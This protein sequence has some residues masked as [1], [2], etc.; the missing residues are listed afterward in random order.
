MEWILWAA[1][2]LLTAVVLALAVKIHLLRRSAREIAAGLSMRL[3]TDTNT[4][5]GISS[6]DRAMRALAESINTDLRALRRE[7]RRLQQGDR[8]LRE[9]VTNISHDLR[10]PLTSIAGTADV[11]LE[12]GPS[13]DD[14][15]RGRLLAGIRDDA[16]WLRDT[17][18][19]LLTVTR[20]EEGGVRPLAD[21]ELVDDLVEEALRHAAADP[22]HPV[23]FEPP[24]GPL[25]VRAD[26]SLV[27]QALVNLVNNAVAHT[28]AGCAVTVFAARSG[29]SVEL[30][31]ADDGPGI[32]DSEKDRIFEAFHSGSGTLPDGTRSAGLGLSVCRAVARAHGGGIRVRDR[33]PHGSV[34]VLSL[35][36]EEVPDV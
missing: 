27:V 35:P 34:F 24:E 33:R 22:A 36:A 28:P 21:V 25:L 3:S 1:A 18:E 16:R 12:A 31:V 2:V 9:A 29:A 5:I 23:R 30:C 10:T 19:N 26:P 15:A 13:L 32:P 20:L 17:V 8:E 14:A 4:L 7:R 11:L 6:R